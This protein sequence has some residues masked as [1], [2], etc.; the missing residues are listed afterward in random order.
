VLAYDFKA[1]CARAVA[2]L[3]QVRDGAQ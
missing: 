3:R 2:S 1:E